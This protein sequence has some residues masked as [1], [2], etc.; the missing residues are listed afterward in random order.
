[1]CVTCPASWAWNLLTTFQFF[2]SMLTEPSPEPRKR[3]SEPAQTLVM[4]LL[5]KSWLASAS[6]GDTWV[7][8]KKSNDF[9]CAKLALLREG[10]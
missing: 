2:P 7:T 5:S 4:S 3:L 9:H 8:S 1:M 10:R 6:G